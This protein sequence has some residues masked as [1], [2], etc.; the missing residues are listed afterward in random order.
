MA[1]HLRA[2]SRLPIVTVLLASGVL[3]AGCGGSSKGS[4]NTVSLS[5][6][7][8]LSTSAT[9][10]KLSMS[11]HES[12]AGKSFDMDGTG[13]FN[14]K[15]RNGSMLMNISVAG[16]T[17]PMQVV[18]ANDTIYEELPSQV[19][20]QLPGGKPWISIDLRQ[21]GRLT[22]IPGL[23]SIMSSGSSMSNPG[24]YLDFLKA[25]SAG[26][27]K[28]L[29]QATVDGVQ[30]THYSAQL[31]LAKLPNAVPPSARSAVSQMMGA[32]QNRFHPS[33]GPINVWLDQSDLV[34]KV[35]MSFSETVAGRS[36]GATITEH[37][38]DYGKQPA[39]TVPPASQ[40]TDIL[41]LIRSGG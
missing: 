16:Q 35:Q 36:V 5:R 41:S 27:V 19:T 24:Q 22:K 31:D 11:M 30:T 8:D 40:T 2:F 14:L 13:A 26:S 38:S 21:L 17:F 1:L 10:M 23:S 15:A 9:G 34:R 4:T 7:A 32:L 25:A 29:G 20:S 37:I 28:N 12:V 3:I 6:A 18:L 33:Y 39:P